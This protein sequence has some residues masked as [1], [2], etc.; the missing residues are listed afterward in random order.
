MDDEKLL[1][2][3]YYIDKNFDGVNELYRKSRKYNKD[4][5][6]EFIIE[7]LKKQIPAQR[8]AQPIKS[9]KSFLPI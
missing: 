5:K 2:K 9:K 1:N 4:I 3:I 6:K 7:W 8:T